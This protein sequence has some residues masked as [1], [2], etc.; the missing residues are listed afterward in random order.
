I[1]SHSRRSDET[2]SVDFGRRL[3]RARTRNQVVPNYGGRSRHH[4]DRQK[5]FFYPWIRKTRRFVL[6]K[7]SRKDKIL[8]SESFAGDSVPARANSIRRSGKSPG[9]YQRKHL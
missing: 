8:L 5:R 1:I 6:R 4:I 9:R 2:K 3:W 7:T